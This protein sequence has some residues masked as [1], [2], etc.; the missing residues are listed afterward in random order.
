MCVGQLGSL[1]PHVV[2]PSIL[3]AFLI[4]EW[5]LTGAQA[6]LLAGSGAAGYMLT[7]PVLATLTDRIDARKILIAGSAVSALGTLLFGL[8]AT[9]LWSGAFFNAIAGIGFAG[10]YMPGLK[11]LTDRLAPGDSSRAITLY[12]SSFSFGVGL[13]FLVSQLVAEAWG[14]R[15][16][17]LVTALGPA[18]DAVGLPAAAAGRR[19]S[20]RRAACWISRRCSA[21]PTRWASSS[22]MA[23]IA[24]SSTASAPGW[25]RSGPLWR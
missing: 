13:S 2:V 24:S 1:L 20:P 6:G 5:H 15:A 9:G 4:P 19:Q 25:S 16:A 14:W 11:A 7:V 17:F 18:G 22:A 12:T 10:A 8:F 21:T 3:A 23:R